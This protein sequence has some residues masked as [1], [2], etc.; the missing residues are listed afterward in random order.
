MT[1]TARHKRRICS[2]PCGKRYLALSPGA[3]VGG[4]ETFGVVMMFGVTGL[5]S[6]PDDTAL[7]ANCARWLE[8]GGCLLV[9]NDINLAEAETITVDH[10][11]GVIKWDWT[12][13]PE[14]RT[15]KLKPEL[16]RTDG[17]VV[18]LRDPIDP[19]RGDH[20]GLPRYIYAVTSRGNFR[21]VRFA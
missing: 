13:D 19:T 3:M 18:G 2:F 16:H 8:H 10:E 4:E 9:D 20:E 11:L 1:V 15:N 14:T 7:I 6:L 17:A 12:S 21:P 5:M